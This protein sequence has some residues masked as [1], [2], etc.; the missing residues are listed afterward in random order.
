MADAVSEAMRLTSSMER[1]IS[2]LV[3]DCYSLAVA[4][5]RI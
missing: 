4:M 5:A 2:S 1:L 3:A